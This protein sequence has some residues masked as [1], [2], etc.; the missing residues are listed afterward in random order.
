MSFTNGD[1]VTIKQN[2][3][4]GPLRGKFGYVISVGTE[5]VNVIL[6]KDYRDQ[7]E[8]GGL[9]YVLYQREIE[10]VSPSHKSE[11]DPAVE[12]PNPDYATLVKAV[13]NLSDES[14]RRFVMN[15][16]NRLLQLEDRVNSAV[17]REQKGPAK[18]DYLELE[19]RL[20]DLEEFVTSLKG[21]VK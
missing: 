16:S 14:A 9:V 4:Y 21:A 15:E 10:V 20:Q 6:E 5:S 17:Q 7:N 8:M 12:D 13:R 1:Y 18:N 2:A 19:K 3:D 11:K